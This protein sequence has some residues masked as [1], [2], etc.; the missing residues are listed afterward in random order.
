[1]TMNFPFIFHLFVKNFD[2]I[3]CNKKKQYFLKT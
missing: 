3:I 1:M 2:P